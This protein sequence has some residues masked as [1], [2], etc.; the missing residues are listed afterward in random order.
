MDDL[1]GLFA[2]VADVLGIGAVSIVENVI[3]MV[4][5]HSRDRKLDLKKPPIFIQKP[6]VI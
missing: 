4:F 2:D 1:S 6:V 5:E 3:P